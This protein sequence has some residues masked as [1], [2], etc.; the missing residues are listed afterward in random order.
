MKKLDSCQLVCLGNKLKVEIESIKFL[1]GDINY[2][3]IHFIDGTYVTV[4]R[5]L[6]HVCE[7]VNAA[8]NFFRINRSY[9]VNIDH[10]QS[11]KNNLICIDDETILK[12]SRRKTK[13][14]R[15]LIN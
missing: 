5:T 15:E 6:K 14:F 9:V 2:T 1:K 13:A 12:P 7:L 10:V 8:N 4:A 11:Y 3:H